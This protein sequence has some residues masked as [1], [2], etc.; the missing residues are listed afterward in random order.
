MGGSNLGRGIFA[1]PLVM[2]SNPCMPP[3]KADY[4][5]DAT[6][7]MSLGALPTRS[8]IFFS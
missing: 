2:A 4:S 6:A 3:S 7:G 5:R 1:T 8:S